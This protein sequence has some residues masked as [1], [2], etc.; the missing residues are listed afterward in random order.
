M[1]V[2]GPVPNQPCQ[3][4]FGVFNVLTFNACF[5][6][7]S[8]NDFIF[9]TQTDAL[10]NHIQGN[11]GIGSENSPRTCETPFE[12]S[13][14]E[15]CIMLET[16][17]DEK[18]AEFEHP[19]FKSPLY[20]DCSGKCIA[21]PENIL[22][23]TY[24]CCNSCQHLS[25]PCDGSCS[26]HRKF[27]F[28]GC[29][30]KCGNEEKANSYSCDGV[31]V[32]RM[33]SC[34]GACHDDSLWKCPNGQRCI[35]YDNVCKSEYTHGCNDHSKNSKT[36][37]EDP[38]GKDK[39]CPS[40]DIKRCKGSRPGQCVDRRRFCD[41]RYDCVDKSDE[42]ECDD[43][44]DNNDVAPQDVEHKIQ[45]EST[46]LE[47]EYDEFG[48]SISK[49]L[50]FNYS[51]TLHDTAANDLNNFLDAARLPATDPV[52]VEKVC[53]DCKPF[54]RQETVDDDDYSTF[55]GCHPDLKG[56]ESSKGFCSNYDYWKNRPCSDQ[57]K[58]SGLE[59]VFHYEKSSGNSP[60]KC[61]STDCNCRQ[62]AVLLSGPDFSE[63]I[64]PL[65]NSFCNE[66]YMRACKDMKTCIHENLFCD[67]YTQCEDGSDENESICSKCP[68][69]F[70]F[71][72]QKLQSATYRCKHRYAG[73]SVCSVPC[74][75]EDDFCQGMGDED[76]QVNFYGLAA[77]IM[78]VITTVS[79]M[80]F[81]PLGMVNA[82]AVFKQQNMNTEMID[83]FLKILSPFLMSTSNGRER[84]KQ[85]KHIFSIYKKIHQCETQKSDVLIIHTSIQSLD[86][87]ERRKASELLY[88][89]ELCFHRAKYQ[90]VSVKSIINMI[91]YNFV[92]DR[93]VHPNS[94]HLM[95]GWRSLTFRI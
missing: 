34:H 63:K 14:N 47:C 30:G 81:I 13:C 23:G 58:P 91:A 48:G 52:Q 51:D 56:Y 54:C 26:R 90:Y 77:G 71:P 94:N 8:F 80:L 10:G 42:E 69:Q 28:L 59:G 79:F 70:G 95:R 3:F 21:F 65:P 92:G 27:N 38:A 45:I 85:F 73:R 78:A 55:D 44:K 86:Y 83:T 2:G 9:S 18:C 35:K 29:D 22:D 43:S 39:G 37:G 40:A 76:C 1:T 64:C 11:T 25:E 4:P 12:W 17:C 72:H 50:S 75:H 67:G 32:N 19:L 62:C 66:P 49:G 46:L 53:I 82:R 16:P 89:L 7:E 84:R 20:L 74:D 61:F 41:G 6:K 93:E 5:V 33:Y 57:A 15:K 60:G 31:C 36:I 24:L 87:E 68:R 88:K